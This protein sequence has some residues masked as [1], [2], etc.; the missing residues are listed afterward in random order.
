MRRH[1][2]NTR[3]ARAIVS[4]LPRVRNR[5]VL[6]ADIVLLA[7]V[8][9]AALA[10]RHNGLG[11]VLAHPG[12][13][14]L[15]TAATVLIRVGALQAFGL[16]RRYWL[17]ATVDDLIAIVLAVVASTGVIGLA[18]AGARLAGLTLTTAPGPVPW[19]GSLL[20][21]FCVGATRFS[22]QI[23][24]HLV[25][26]AP[27]P[28]ALRTLIV[29]AGFSG[30]WIARELLHSNPRAGLRPIAF[31]DD[32]TDKQHVSILTLPVVGRIEDLPDVTRQLRVEQVV[33][34]IPGAPGKLIRRING[35]CEEAGVDARTLPGI[36]SIL[37]GSIRVSQLRKVDIEDLLRREPIVTDTAA[38]RR[39]IDGKRVLITGGGGSIGGELC[40]QV[41]QCRPAGLVVLGHG[42]NSVFDIHNELLRMCDDLK[43]PPDSEPGAHKPHVSAQIG[44]IRSPER[45]RGVMERFRPDIVFHAAAHKHVPLMEWNPTEAVSNNVLGT[46]NLLAAAEE[47]G[48]EHFVMISTDKAVNP[49]NVMGASKR[50]AE[51][52]VMEAARR[53]GR[54][55]V[56]VRF[57]NVLGSRGSVVPTFKRQIDGGGPVTVSDPEMR[58]FFMTIP[59]AVQLVLQASVLGQGG[60]IFMLDMGEPVKIVDLARDIIELSGLEVGRDIEIVFTGTRPGEKLF[61]ELFLPGETY[62]ETHHE[63]IRIARSA[64]S[65]VPPGITQIVREMENLVTSDDAEAAVRWLQCLVPEYRPHDSGA[66]RAVAPAASPGPVTA[67]TPGSGKRNRPSAPATRPSRA[68]AGSGTRPASGGGRESGRAS[69]SS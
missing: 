55:Y 58:R 14:A 18:H 50:A 33:I 29:G 40:R 26:E 39:F 45:L 5:H 16:Y 28:D 21:L 63:K 53:T 1:I 61:E 49:T 51:L 20:T 17:Y 27:H 25:R 54:A 38:V 19:L 42:E 64:G 44:D 23:L 67:A 31:L 48:V 6:V 60:E 30:Q 62:E 36:S 35:L 22:V 9:T 37:T 3:L 4:L 13:F 32:D 59:E 12:E 66:V 24:A 47:F 2:A 11:D 10:L 7:V 15:Y 56:A 68:R 46:R 34:A 57:G 52:L 8:P 43:S 69:H 41:L 65:A